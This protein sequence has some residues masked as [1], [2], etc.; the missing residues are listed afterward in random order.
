[1]YSVVLMA[2]LTTGGSAPDCH[3]GHGCHGYSSCHG[4][5]GCSGCYG[6]WGSAGGWA[7]SCNYA[8][9]G[10][11]T[12]GSWGGGTGYTETKRVLVRAG[13][14]ARADFPELESRLALAKR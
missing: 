12:F 7:C 8:C 14:E 4:C 13:Q 1:M 11:Y 3:W 9:W 5:A 2:A 6:G 10:G